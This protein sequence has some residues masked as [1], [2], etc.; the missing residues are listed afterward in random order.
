MLDNN[1]PRDKNG[2][3]LDVRGNRDLIFNEWHRKNLLPSCYVTDVDFLEY[4]YSNGELIL[5]AILEVK[6]WH[7]S[8]P[9]YVEDSTNFKAIQKLANIAKLPFFF[10]WYEKDN[11]FIKKFK[12][13]DVFNEDKSEAK[14]MNPNEFKSFIEKL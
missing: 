5:K 4:R 12:I 6:E 11:D 14:E 13:W 8:E 7:V 3:R 1:L 2:I 9:K 10:V